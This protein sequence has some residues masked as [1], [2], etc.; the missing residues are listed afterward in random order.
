MKRIIHYFCLATAFAGLI[1]GFSSCD[2]TNTHRGGRIDPE[3]PDDPN[4]PGGDTETSRDITFTDGY[5]R[6]Y[7]PYYND[8]TDNYLINLYAGETDQ[9]WNLVSSGYRLTLDII[10]PKSNEIAFKEGVYDCSDEDNTTFI[11]VPTYDNRDEQGNSFPDGSVFYFQRDRQNSQNFFIS[12]GKLVVKKYVTGQIGIEGNIKAGGVDYTIHYKGSLEITDMTGGG[13]DVPYDVEMKNISRVVAVDCGQVWEGIEC[14][15]YRDWIL[16]F[17][18]KDAA[19]TSE[20][21]CVEFLTKEDVRGSFPEMKLN[22]VVQVGNPSDFVPGVIIGGYTDEDNYVWGTWY[23]K[24]GYGEYAASKGSLEIKPSGN[25]YSM[26]FDF[27][28]EDETYGGTFKG[29]YS[30]PVE[31]TVDQGASQAPRKAAGKFFSPH[32]GTAAARSARPAVRNRAH[33]SVK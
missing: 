9:D 19:T 12:D 33:A 18:D 2:V 24:G 1:A 28:D 29:S 7:G 26:S 4:R 21:T 25:G 23:C 5:G 15:D 20:Y 31:F 22:K 8:K 17:Y 6:F 16:Y 3:Y 27:V 10:L 13:G 30:G 32:R 11:F 14:T